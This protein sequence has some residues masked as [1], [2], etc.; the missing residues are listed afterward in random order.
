[1]EPTV[2]V[3]LKGKHGKSNSTG[4]SHI[5]Q[6]RATAQNCGTALAYVRNT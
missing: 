6:S 1:M 5:G 2:Y 4:I 3:T